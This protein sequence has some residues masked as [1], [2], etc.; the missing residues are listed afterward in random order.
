MSVCVSSRMLTVN[1]APTVSQA[2]M[3]RPGWRATV[4]CGGLNE[5]CCTQLASMPV[6]TSPLRAVST[7][8]PLGIR[9]RAAAR[10]L[11]GV[12]AVTGPSSLLGRG[13][14]QQIDDQGIHHRM[15]D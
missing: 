13:L 5:H 10:L 15:T 12:L 3:S 6:S 9:P 1:A 11:A 7:K 4:T 2:A 14:L 8:R